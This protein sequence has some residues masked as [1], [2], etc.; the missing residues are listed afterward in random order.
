MSG[1]YR[2]RVLVL[3]KTRLGESD[4]IVTALSAE[5]H[6]IR[7]VAKGGRKPGSRFG[8]RVE[9]FTVIDGLFARGRTLDVLTEAQTVVTHDR[10]RADYDAV[11]AAAVVADFLDRVTV[12]SDAEPRL[13]ELGL[14]ALAAIED[15]SAEAL[16]TLV[17]AFLVKGM[18]MQG[19]RPQLSACVSCGG[20]CGSPVAFSSAGGGTLCA[21]CLGDDA[22]A[23]GVSDHLPGMLR[24]LLR[25]RLAEAAAEP[26]SEHAAREALVVLRSFAAH[27]VPARMRALDAYLRG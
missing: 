18:A 27:H 19:L 16:S 3:R 12:E 14:A 1:S 21:A 9:P 15:A 24:W 25:A 26:L 13:Y 4:L 5:G 6:Q 23:V 20:A 11:R 10:L 7:A 2:A 17:A 22:S 8:A